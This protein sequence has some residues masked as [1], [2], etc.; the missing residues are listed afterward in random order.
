MENKKRKRTNNIVF[1]KCFLCEHVT[2]NKSSMSAHCESVKH[3]INNFEKNKT[4]YHC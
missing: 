1:Y 2:T 3:L 4:T